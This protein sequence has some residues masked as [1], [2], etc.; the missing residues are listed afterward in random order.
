MP[1]RAGLR[2]TFHDLQNNVAAIRMWL[3]MLPACTECRSGQEKAL[4]RIRRNLDQA[5]ATL[6]KLESLLSPDPNAALRYSRTAGMSGGPFA[7]A[8]ASK[9]QGRNGSTRRVKSAA[10]ASRAHL[11]N[12]SAAQPQR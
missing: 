9:P 4:V 5:R 7:R 12:G 10:A 6:G 3:V 1:K 8:S 2:R 11:R